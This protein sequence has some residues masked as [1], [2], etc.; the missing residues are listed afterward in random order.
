MI[1][2]LGVMG[3]CVVIEAF[4]DC[5]SNVS[6][7]VVKA[8]DGAVVVVA[9]VVTLVVVDVV[10]AMMLTLV[11]VVVTGAVDVIDVD[12]HAGTIPTRAPVHTLQV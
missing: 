5:G 7:C 2:E 12:V 9:V 3:P 6:V 10:L 4:G 11:L 1:A 8:D